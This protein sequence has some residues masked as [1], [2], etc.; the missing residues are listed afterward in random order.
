[1]SGHLVFGDNLHVLR[2]TIRAESIDLIYLDP[3]FNSNANYNVLFKSPK[4]SDADAQIQAFDDTWHW[5][6]VAEEAYEDVLRT[7]SQTAMML[8]ALRSTLG[9]NDMMAYLAMMTARLVELHRVLKPTGSLYLHCDPTASHY[10]KIILDSLFGAP[11]FRNE[12]TWKR[13]SAHSDGARYGRNT[14]TLLYFSKSNDR[15]WNQVF[16]DYDEQYK[17]RF[18]N[19][20]ADGRLWTDD[21]LTA[22]GLSGGGYEYEYKDCKNLWRMPLETMERLDRENRLYFTSKG[23]IRL[24]RYL[25]E[26]D[27]M[28]VQALWDDINPLN[29]QSRERLGYPTQKPLA[30]LERVIAASSNEDDL[31]LDPF[32]GCGTTVHAAEKMKRNWIGIDVTH[33]AIQV[34]IDRM[35][36]NHP[37]AAQKMTISGIPTTTEDAKELAKRDKLQA[38]FWAVSQVGGH[39]KGYAGA[40]RGIDGQFFFKAER[41]TDGRGI[42]SVKAGKNIGPAMVRE[43]QGTVSREG[44][45]IGV[46]ITAEKPTRAMITDA[47]AAGF[48]EQGLHRYPKIQIISFEDIFNNNGINCPPLYTTATLGD[49][50][51]K[52][53]SKAKK[54]KRN[55][56]L[57][58]DELK[59][60][61]MLLPIVSKQEKSAGLAENRQDKLAEALSFTPKKRA[62]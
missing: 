7:G 54:G 56:T 34:I 38:E 44:A 24:K 31:V 10:L 35:S 9:E 33:I 6:T 1:M 46:L 60:R 55:Q 13:T 39:P 17:A 8:R 30:L 25:D 40:D 61:N 43:L 22:K 45:E 20:D 52:S 3:P 49:A 23:G 32:C 48:H 19:K 11:N 53:Q 14:D 28:P 26:A 2:E 41:N 29:S 18:R 42:I 47:A 36:K 27:G 5:T 4:G 21:N 57:P 12:I 16:R 37:A 62:I 59:Q 58:Q 51:R 15:T 50:T